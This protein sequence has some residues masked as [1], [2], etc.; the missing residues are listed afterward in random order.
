M[1]EIV[2]LWAKQ[3]VN[4]ALYHYNRPNTTLIYN[5]LLNSK[6]LMWHKS[7]NQTRPYRLLAIEGEM[8]HVQL[9]NKPTSFRSTSIKPYFQPKNTHNVKLDELE[10][11]TK[12]DKLE[13]PLPTL[14]VPYKLT[15]PAKPAIKRG[16]GRP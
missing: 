16:R 9:P 13:V 10:A 3:T 6:V 1:A 15:K 7:G 11:T 8:C 2:K 4:S 12:L 5:L 14:E